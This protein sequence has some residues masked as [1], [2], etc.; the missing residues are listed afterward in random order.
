MLLP[1]IR[2]ML[3]K[4]GTEQF[5]QLL[6]RVAV[7]RFVAIVVVVVATVVKEFSC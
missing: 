4:W 6:M 1:L 2:K 3:H 7:P 5:F